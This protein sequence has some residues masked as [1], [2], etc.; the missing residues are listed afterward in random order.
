VII[1]LGA[2]IVGEVMIEVMDVNRDF[3]FESVFD[4]RLQLREG[5]RWHLQVCKGHVDESDPVHE[6]LP[7]LLVG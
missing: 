4:D 7:A 5:D 2:E 1:E 6:N 3:V